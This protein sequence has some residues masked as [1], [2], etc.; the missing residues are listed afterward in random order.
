MT[1]AISHGSP[2][3]GAAV[4][5]LRR[6]VLVDAGR[7]LAFSVFTEQIGAW[8]PLGDH[9]VHGADASVAFVDPGVGARILES[10]NG[11]TDGADDA[12]WGTVTRWEPGVLV[13]FT[14]HPGK[15]PD[16]ASHVTVTFEESDGKTL[17]RL[18]HAGWEIFGEY[19]AQ[20]REEYDHGWPVVLGAYAAQFGA[21]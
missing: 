19:A 16:E 13:A 7:D 21:A 3:S 14:W 11:D 15:G 17:V 10:R 6:E 1:T 5:P 20:A 9:S 12:V 8:W 4:P 2:G 18:E